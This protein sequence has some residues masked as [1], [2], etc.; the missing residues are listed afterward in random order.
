MNSPRAF[1]LLSW[2]RLATA[3]VRSSCS[4]GPQMTGEKAS[5]QSAA[6]CQAFLLSL[7]RSL[8]CL[9]RS[10]DFLRG[11]EMRVRLVPV[12]LIAHLETSA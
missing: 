12:T 5:T 8:D 3:A 4:I 9:P 6:M 10:P 11:G 7:E 2:A 1:I